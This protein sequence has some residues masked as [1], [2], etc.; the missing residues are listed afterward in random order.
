MKFNQYTWN[1][2]KQSS[3]GQKVIREFEEMDGYTLLRK[4]TPY[5][6]RFISEDLYNDWLETIHCYGISDCE[7]PTSLDE[8]QDFYEALITLGIMDNGEYGFLAMILE[9]CLDSFNPYHI[10]YQDLHRNSFSR[11]YLHVVSST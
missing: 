4:Y 9:I 3:E 6:T 1:L 8:A 5:Y 7:V 11:I 10:F 2:Y